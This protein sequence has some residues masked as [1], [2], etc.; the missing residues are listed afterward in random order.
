MSGFHLRLMHRNEA[1]L[2]SSR[3]SKRAD[4]GASPAWLKLS[5]RAIQVHSDT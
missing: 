4:M 3:N 5:N 1:A 2:E